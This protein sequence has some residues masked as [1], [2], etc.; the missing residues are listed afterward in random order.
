MRIIY[1]TFLFAGIFIL[2]V[3]AQ[4]EL[5]TEQNA[6]GRSPKFFQ[7]LLNFSSGQ[8]G[9]TRVDVF[10]QIPY[11]SI[12]FIKSENKFIADYIINLSVFN[13]DKEKVIAEKTWDSKVEVKNFDESVSKNNY[14]LNLKSFYLHPG[15]YVLRSSVQDKESNKEFPLESK[16]T[17]RN[18]S[19][20][21]ALSDIMFLN[22]RYEEDGKNKISPNISRN[23]AYIQNGLPVFY[24]LYSQK[25]HKL[26]LIYTISDDKKQTVFE[27]TTYRNVDTGKT[28]IFYTLKDSSF[29]FGYYT[30]QIQAGDSANNRVVAEVS[31]SFFSRWIGMPVSITDLDKAT[32]EMV[33]IASAS[34]ISHIKNAETKNEK[35]KRFKE[36]WKTQDPTPSTEENEVF[37]EYYRRVA[38]ANAHFSRYFQGWR[39]DMGMVFILLGPPNNVERHPF[40]IDS[41]PYE[42]WSY[43]QLNQ[44]FVF[45][46]DTGFGDYRLITPITGELYR[47]RR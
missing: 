14:T 25:P 34:E 3:S 47:F 6:Y 27:D 37:D 18:L 39:T 21:V 9:T 11:T 24:E 1:L 41:K 2:P 13:E 33:Y 38:Y 42:V 28:Q 10:I 5:A 45:I 12:Q 19:G 20:N 46:D 44:S 17:V 36:F 16:F 4:V 31:K 15:K 35:L 30:L 32:D 40:D 23:V 22:K 7:E 8:S 29:S 26:F 43:Y